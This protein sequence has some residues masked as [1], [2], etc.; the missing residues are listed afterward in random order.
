MFGRTVGGLQ[1]GRSAQTIA[2]QPGKQ[3]EGMFPSEPTA[4][5]AADLNNPLAM[6]STA[7]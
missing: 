3:V 6:T 5:A 4:L 7:Q 1:A 2:A